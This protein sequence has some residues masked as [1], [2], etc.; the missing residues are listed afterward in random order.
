[1]I[2]DRAG[3]SPDD[4]VFEI[5]AGLGALTVPLAGR[6]KKVY[7]V[8]KDR[9]LI[10][11]LKTE[12]QVA[13]AS[14]IVLIDKNIQDIDISSISKENQSR[15]IIMGN[16]PYNISTQILIQIIESREAVSRAIVMLQKEVAR[17]IV[18]EPG[19]KEYG[20]LSVMLQYCSNIKRVAEVRAA[21]FFPKPKVDSEV[22]EMQIQHVPPWPAMDE[23]HLFAVVK[24]AFGKRRK[25]LKNALTGGLPIDAEAARA[26]LEEAGID[27]VRRAES[28]SVEEFVKLSN[29]MISF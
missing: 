18:A 5:G 21:L 10:P 1:M 15:L 19:G 16:L 28:L 9:R 3:I 4:I 6:A 8:E 11:L 14:N 29:R 7:A 13:G 12:L 22:I 25:T 2:I 20:R 17:R 26:A 24:A 23:A 27:P